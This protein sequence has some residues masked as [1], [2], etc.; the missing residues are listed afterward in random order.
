[1]WKTIVLIPKGQG[2]YRGIGL[3]D[4]I[5]KVCTSIVIS[6]LK[7]SIVLHDVVHG[8]R[9]GRGTGTAIIEAKLEPQLTRDSSRSIFS[10]LH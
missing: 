8:F 10:G 3:V 6:R 7:S 9:Q 5:W 2:E 1:M 4:T